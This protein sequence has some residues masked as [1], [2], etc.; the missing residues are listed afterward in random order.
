MNCPC[1]VVY[2]GGGTN[3]NCPGCGH[4]QHGEVCQGGRETPS[5]LDYQASDFPSPDPDE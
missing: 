1:K 2:L 4:P 5:D 3:K